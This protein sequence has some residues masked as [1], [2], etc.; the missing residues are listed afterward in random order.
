MTDK[1]Q[2]VGTA[3][4]QGQAAESAR[5]QGQA[6]GTARTQ[7]ARRAMYFRMITASFA[8]RFSRMVVA[9]LAIIVG[10][11]V[12][13]GLVTIYYDMPRQMGMQFRSYGANMI[14]VPSD[15]AQGGMTRADID[16]ALAQVSNDELVGV[17]TYHYENCTINA[18]PLVVAGADLEATRATSPYWYVT[19]EWPD[20][21]GEVLVGLVEADFF[22]LEVGDTV[23]ITHTLVASDDGRSA[24]EES[25]V[26]FVVSGLL[27]TGGSEEEYFFISNDDMA[28]LTQAEP[29]YN[30]AEL[31]IQADAERLEALSEAISQE[32]P[33]VTPQ[34]VKRLTTSETTVLTKLQALVF[35]VTVVVLALTM[36]CV[37]TTMTAVVT[38]RR[39]EIG[40]RKALGASDK[41]IVLEFMGEGL[42]QG[43]LGGLIGAGLGFGFAQ[44]V[45]TNVF[46]SSIT[47]RPLLIP[48][49][50]LAALV[51]TG[52]ACAL[53]VRNA[54]TV[55]P[56]LVLK[57]E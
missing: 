31:S 35:L 50:V 10:A 19:G 25:S 21:P 26:D 11:T 16:Q 5:T 30:I 1:R 17:S 43:A 20:E 33:N 14:L 9:L 38:E 41:S 22:S 13:S 15:S 7:A 47:F 4:T 48:I 55:D 12:L 34:L 36:I 28:R 2:T 18:S 51:V 52:L 29:S 32:V 53:P 8:R 23:T 42:L 45:S 56:A 46:N 49:T 39:R 57:G 37:A 54:T 44:L 40:L 3:R 27:D 24:L 6:T